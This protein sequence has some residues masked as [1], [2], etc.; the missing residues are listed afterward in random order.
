MQDVCGLPSVAV[1][2]GAL[3]IA[4]HHLVSGWAFD[5]DAPLETW[6]ILLTA[7]GV[8]L[9]QVLADITRPDLVRLGLTGARGF[10]LQI[11]GGLQPFMRHVIEARCACDGRLLAQNRMVVEPLPF[12]VSPAL[13]S[14]GGE[15]R[16]HVDTVER[17]RIS[18]WAVDARRPGEAVSLQVLDNGCLIGRMVANIRRPDLAAAGYGDGRHGFEVLF[19][20]HLS[21]SL[22]HVIQVR[23]ENLGTELHGSPHV[24]GEA[25]SFDAGLMTTIERAIAASTADTRQQ[26]FDFL[27]ESLDR[28][29]QMQADDSAGRVKRLF[30]QRRHALLDAGPE[31][32]CPPRRVLIID[33]RL[34]VKERDA[35]SAA[36]LS[37]I[38]ALQEL[39]YQAVI[40]SSETGVNADQ[41]ACAL[42]ARG[43]EVCKPPFY[44]SVEDVLSRQSD[45]FDLVYLHRGP[46]A[47]RYI[48][49]ARYWQ[50]GARLL[51]SVADLHHVR[52]AR[53]AYL[54]KRPE[55]G[56]LVLR[57]KM[58]E[59]YAG[60]SADV[61]VTHSSEEATMLRGV[62]P[63]MNVV[64]VPW[65]FDPRPIT[66]KFEQRSGIA[67]IGNF[68]HAPNID[69]ANWLA[70]DLMPMIRALDPT[71]NCR[72]VG[73]SMPSEL[74]RLEREGLVV[75]GYID[76][77]WDIM[78]EIRLTIAPLRFGA[79]VKGK[80]LSSFAH[81]L[82][83]VMTG[84]AAE[85][86][87]L[88]GPLKSLVVENPGDFARKIVALHSNRAE[89]R[90][91]SRAARTFI[92]Q[93]NSRECVRA[94]L[95][96]ALSSCG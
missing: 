66:R 56:P 61:V 67:F 14:G 80:V 64:R 52:L 48:G 2:F 91:L 54:Q 16:G 84:V 85:G 42:E 33:E 15:I 6:T 22:R 50:P 29:K 25:L 78:D 87:A 58:E 20:T 92:E 27:T 3:E 77:L 93:E 40:A 65:A 41:A 94:K 37:H 38:E 11:A 23:S 82:P 47:A 39:D 55:M 1:L 74:R 60:W 83:C 5:P 95:E 35:G 18:G 46:V 86:L 70:E 8:T 4:N 26:T 69:A 63:K 24:I 73:A 32:S 30:Y 68:A 75:E 76:D 79:G 49:L 89:N 53:Q 96:E 7:N 90:R 88:K 71:I 36:L 34:P 10:K 31:I 9:G 21:S 57:S 28:L 44:S 51:Y 17:H 13:A 72:V 81:G 12:A 62:V 19:P 59:F 43:I 45:T